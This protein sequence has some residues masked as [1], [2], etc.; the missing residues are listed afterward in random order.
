MKEQFG[1]T[2]DWQKPGSASHQVLRD[3]EIHLWWL[4]LQLNPEQSKSA[5]KLLSDVQQDKYH[6][7]RTQGLKQAY[8]AGRYFLLNLLGHYTETPADK[9][10]LDYS[11]L[12]KPYLK[13]PQFNLQ[14]NLSDT[15]IGDDYFGAFVF[16]K[17]RSVGVDIEWLHRKANFTAIATHR[18]SAEEQ[19]YVADGSGGVNQQRSLAIW[20]R[21]EAFG[22]A[23][24]LV[25]DD[26]FEVY[27]ASHDDEWRLKQIQ[28]DQEIIACIA[29]RSHRNLKIK[30]FNWTN[31]FD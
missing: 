6:R 14:F 21:K 20:T 24:N 30:A 31:H 11:E 5:F 25:N 18:F 13:N 3:G 23:L 16:C 8:L 28:I 12:N 2:I 17:G 4:P 10:L 22:N 7:R 15:Q 29:H 26:D 19:A 9:V 1:S 27:F